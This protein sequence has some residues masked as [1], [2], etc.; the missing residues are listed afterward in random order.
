MSW[1]SVTKSKSEEVLGIRDFS[2]WNK[3]YILKIIW[4]I[5]FN[6]SSIRSSW[7]IKEVLEGNVD[8]L[9]VINTKQKHSWLANELILH[10]DLIYPWIKMAIGNGE[11]CYYWS[12]N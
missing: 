2:I 10:R 7:F 12:S 6:Q 8:N 3:A 1:E 9:W 4:L 5:F 11:R